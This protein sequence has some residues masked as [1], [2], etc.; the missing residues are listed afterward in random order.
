MLGLC[1]YFIPCFSVA[2]SYNNKLKV[3]DTLLLDTTREY[4]TG[5]KFPNPVVLPGEKLY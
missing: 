1:I 4:V 3:F 5:Y 2:K